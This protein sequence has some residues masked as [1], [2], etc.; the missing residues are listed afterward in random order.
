MINL[1]DDISLYCMQADIWYE[2][3]WRC[4]S[5]NNPLLLGNVYYCSFAENYI[6]PVNEYERE[7]LEQVGVSSGYSTRVFNFCVL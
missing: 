5:I 6:R 2:I 3:H 4:N 1:I 7:S